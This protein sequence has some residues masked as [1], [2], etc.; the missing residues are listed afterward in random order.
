MVLSQYLILGYL[1]PWV[2]SSP[3]VT[4]IEGIRVEARRASVAASGGGW[5]Q[6]SN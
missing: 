5:Q 3:G 6:D 1:G 2:D 4:G